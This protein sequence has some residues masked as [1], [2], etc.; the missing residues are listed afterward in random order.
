MKREYE[1]MRFLPCREVKMRHGPSRA[2][3]LNR[4]LLHRRKVRTGNALMLPYR[5]YRCSSHTQK[6]KRRRGMRSC[7]A[8]VFAAIPSTQN[9]K[10]EVW[11]C[12][13]ATSN[14]AYQLRSLQGI[15]SDRHTIR[16][17]DT[18]DQLVLCMH[19]EEHTLVSAP[20]Q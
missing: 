5:H 13:D 6:E 1:S 17:V 19:L 3:F 11:E 14:R 20:P 2:H 10:Q 4:H 7:F 9:R 12:A 16:R 15:M 8:I 18:S